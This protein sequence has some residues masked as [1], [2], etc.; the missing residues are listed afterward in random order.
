MSEA[1]V[2]TTSL[3][4]GRIGCIVTGE[5]SQQELEKTPSHSDAQT[6]PTETQYVTTR[7]WSKP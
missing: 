4:P 7:Q 3:S 2:F 5:E 6:A 1:D